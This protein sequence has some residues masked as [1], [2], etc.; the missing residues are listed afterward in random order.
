MGANDPAEML[1]VA[2]AEIARLEAENA[3]LRNQVEFFEE[4]GLSLLLTHVRLKLEAERDALAASLAQA[5]E[6]IQRLADAQQSWIDAGRHEQTISREAI[7]DRA[8]AIVEALVDPSEVLRSHDEKTWYEGFRSGHYTPT[9]IANGLDFCEC[10]EN[11]YRRVQE[12][13]R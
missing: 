5:R 12:G 8:L 11:P 7:R 4:L 6:A 9:E 10:G 13:D 1:V 2:K 3:E